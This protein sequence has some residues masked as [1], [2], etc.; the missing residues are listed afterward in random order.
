MPFNE[1]LD[2]FFNKILKPVLTEVGYR[3]TRGDSV[4]DQ[5]NVLRDIVCGIGS[6]DLIVADL[7]GLNAN[8]FYELGLAH[9]LAIP[10]VLLTQD[11]AT[12]P[13]DL[14]G[15]RLKPYDTQFHKVAE[16]KDWLRDVATE[17]AAGK[18]RF[19][20][21][22]TDFLPAD[23]RVE[24][25]RGLVGDEADFALRDLTPALPRV[26][27]CV[28]SMLEDVDFLTDRAA[29]AAV[30]TGF[31]LPRFR[32]VGNQYL[33]KRGPDG[34]VVA[35]GIVESLRAFAEELEPVLVRLE[36]RNKELR[37]GPLASMTFS[38][39]GSL[40]EVDVIKRTMLRLNSAMP[41]L[42]DRTERL[43][44]SLV[45]LSTKRRDVQS[46][47]QRNQAIWERVVN[48]ADSASAFGQRM[49]HVLD[50]ATE[51]ADNE[52]AVSPVEGG[53]I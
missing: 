9:G 6:A 10:T 45:P 41:E 5:Q 1:Q 32:R 2:P 42:K 4:L 14:R 33:N 34:K 46:E 21:P 48:T 11:V 18:I 40:R 43:M 28:E 17:H 15:Y 20:N 25:G 35:D 12:V 50:V 26:I 39:L 49:L 37:T 24:R 44:E 23:I 7:T 19:G 52:E 38:N 51:M 22:V 31:H 36:Q 53:A 8:V 16:F 27:D 29:S 47:V 3:V 13:F 30:L